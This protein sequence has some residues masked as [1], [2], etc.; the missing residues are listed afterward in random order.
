MGNVIIIAGLVLIIFFAGKSSIGHFRGEGGCCGGG[1]GE[2]PEKKKLEGKK[3][4]EKII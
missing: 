4:G 2:K 1:S 3:I